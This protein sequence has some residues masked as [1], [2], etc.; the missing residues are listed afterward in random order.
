MGGALR[1]LR[2]GTLPS[3]NLWRHKPFVSLLLRELGVRPASLKMPAFEAPP[4]KFGR[5]QVRYAIVRMQKAGIASEFVDGA[6]GVI[7]ET[8]SC[9][10]KGTLN[11][12]SE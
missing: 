5:H 1:L 4:F 12:W 6:A 2:G 9:K 7:Q 8:T 10:L 3:N 11:Y